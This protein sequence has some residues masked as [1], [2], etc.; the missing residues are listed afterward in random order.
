MMARLAPKK[1][2]VMDSLTFGRLNLDGVHLSGASYALDDARIVTALRK[3]GVD[4][5][6]YQGRADGQMQDIAR[7][8][9]RTRA[10]T[11]VFYVVPQ[12]MNATVFLLNEIS[13]VR[14]SASF[15]FWGCEDFAD[16]REYPASLTVVPSTSPAEVVAELAGHLG[17]ERS[18]VSPASPYLEGTL[19]IADLTR[20][21]LSADSWAQ[22]RQFA[23]EL[24]WMSRSMDVLDGMVTLHI[25]GHEQQ[26][27]IDVADAIVNAGV[28]SRLTVTMSGDACGK[29]SLLALAAA[30]VGRVGIRGVPSDDG[31]DGAAIP[32]TVTRLDIDPS[33]RSSIYAVNGMITY[34]S[35]MYMDVGRN[36]SPGIHHLRLPA[37]ETRVR[38]GMRSVYG[39]NLA[40]RSAEIVADDDV[41]TLDPA[42]DDGWPRHTYSRIGPTSEG[43]DL[44]I[45]GNVASRGRT[46]FVPLGE[47]DESANRDADMTIVTIRTKDDVVDLE[48]RI[49]KFHNEGALVAATSEHPV[50]FENSCRWTRYGGCRVASLRRL[51]ID[52]EG[53][54]STCIDAGAIAKGGTP[55]ETLLVMTRQ[56]SQQED[57]R[58]GCATCPV[59]SEC[60]RCS[61]L[62][63]P[64]S[65][66]YCTL[67]RT[68]PLT[69]LY[70]ELMAFPHIL[71]SR[72][73]GDSIEMRVSG[74]GLPSLI[75]P[76][77]AT[78]PRS[79]DRPLFIAAGGAYFAWWRGTR[80]VVRLS[81]PL[82][83]MAEGWW[84][85]VD[86]AAVVEKLAVDHGVDEL[87]AA[88]SFRDGMAKLAQ[89]GVVHG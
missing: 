83:A 68:Y 64:Y 33:E 69:A 48:R 18:S 15:V 34:H 73:T 26:L 45:D 19:G 12:T 1:G 32:L 75:W 81:L 11:Y 17:H 79:G 84:L 57:T 66:H 29:R 72:I 7:Q 25:S 24:A 53:N 9:A 89:G 39:A 77:V 65:D 10:A 82:V 88:E 80:R 16:L 47:L 20:L 5:G 38:R 58:R 42:A 46:V 67:R 59:R 36:P 43:K 13:R 4:A 2:S 60:S 49:S 56:R 85:G 14:S 70:F 86:D 87:V 62:P 6:I 28:G 30:G 63:A 52:Q 44:Y 27:V 35:G 41:I 3:L 51:D 21:G 71:G 78:E 76:N 40:L 37:R 55:Y 23:D 50:Y 74:G 54:V 22:G 31:V 8:F 61:A